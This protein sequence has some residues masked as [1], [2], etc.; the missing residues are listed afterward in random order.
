VFA[1]TLVATTATAG[2][3]SGTAHAS[4]VRRPAAVLEALVRS[5]SSDQAA[6]TPRRC[7]YAARC[8]SSDPAVSLVIVSTGDTTSCR[9]RNTVSWG[10]G[11]KTTKTYSGD[12]DG[13]KLATIKYTYPDVPK[14]FVV[15]VTGKTTAGSCFVATGTLGFTL[16]CPAAPA[17]RH[18]GTRVATTPNWVGYVA[19]TSPRGTG[20]GFTGVTGRWAQPAVKCPEKNIGDQEVDFWVGLD[21]L[22]NDSSHTVEQTGVEV[23]CLWDADSS[24]YDGPRYRAWYEMYPDP[25]VYDGNGYPELE[26]TP[27]TTVTATV[28]YDGDAKQ[29]PYTLTLTVTSGDQT[30][31]GTV[32][33]AC[34][35]AKKKA[36]INTNAEWITEQVDG[37]GIASFA[38]WKLTAG[39]ATTRTNP[40]NQSVAE[41]RATAFDLQPHPPDGATLAYACRLKGATFTVQQH[42][43]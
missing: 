15:K 11:V 3:W 41:L 42:A 4:T 13:S 43:C 30:N 17:G 16:M 27:G 40:T 6:T 2:G 31:I 10:D 19:R 24:T 39:Y 12:V 18:A 36:C 35:N 21:G 33:Q 7:F 9:F 5:K 14:F 38:P 8:A 28:T 32:D 29:N 34:L 26:P 37:R 23:T 20:C 1:L 25:P 22:E